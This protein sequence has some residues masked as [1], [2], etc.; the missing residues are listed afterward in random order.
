MVDS[1]TLNF[2]LSLCFRSALPLFP[3]FYIWQSSPYIE[4]K[5]IAADNGNEDNNDN[6]NNNCLTGGCKLNS[7]GIYNVHI[8]IRVCGEECHS[9][10]A[11]TL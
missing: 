5:A 10:F 11:S 3:H 9:H 6:N 1:S 2:S 7:L 4:K 8:Y